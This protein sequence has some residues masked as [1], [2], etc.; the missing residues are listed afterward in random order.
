MKKDI[1]TIVYICNKDFPKH[2][3]EVG[4][5]FPHYL[6]TKE[7]IEQALKKGSIAIDNNF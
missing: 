5:V 4:D 7:A 2:G 3:L 6:Y 1:K